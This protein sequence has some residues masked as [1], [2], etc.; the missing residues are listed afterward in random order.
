MLWHIRLHAGKSESRLL[1][2]DDFH[3]NTQDAGESSRLTT[4]CACSCGFRPLADARNGRVHALDFVIIRTTAIRSSRALYP[5]R[6]TPDLEPVIGVPA[7]HPRSH[8]CL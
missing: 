8:V 6:F 3:G 4:V 1:Q 5:P 7:P 2:D